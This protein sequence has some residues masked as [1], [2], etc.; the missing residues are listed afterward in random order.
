MG[1]AGRLGDGYC[2]SEIRRVQLREALYHV[3]LRVKLR[4]RIDVVQSRNHMI[5]YRGTMREGDTKIIRDGENH[6]RGGK[7]D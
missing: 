5:E 7:S 4:M 3:V 2:E 6:E 1:L